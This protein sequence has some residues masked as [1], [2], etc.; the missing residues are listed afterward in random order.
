M[1]LLQLLQGID[2]DEEDIWVCVF[3][4]LAILVVFVVVVALVES[5]S[6]A[7]VTSLTVDVTMLGLAA[8]LDTM[9]AMAAVVAG[10]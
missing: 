7:P 5:N 10:I 8:L 9:L 2:D 3:D 6:L 1:Q 4:D